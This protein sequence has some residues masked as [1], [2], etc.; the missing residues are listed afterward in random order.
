MADAHSDDQMTVAIGAASPPI[1]SLQ[2]GSVAEPLFGAALSFHSGSWERVASA[3]MISYRHHDGDYLV[4]Q[5][6]STSILRFQVADLSPRFLC[7]VY[8]L[9]MQSGYLTYPN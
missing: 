5:Q 9:E 6:R 7:R 4:I 1:F 3:N 2:H 8:L